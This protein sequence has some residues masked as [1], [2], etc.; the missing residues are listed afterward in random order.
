MHQIHLTMAAGTSRNAPR[1]IVEAE[2]F[3]IKKHT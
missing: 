3:Q 2:S 1:G